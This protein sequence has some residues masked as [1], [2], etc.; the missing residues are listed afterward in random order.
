[1]VAKNDGLSNFLSNF[2][3]LS[4]FFKLA[5]QKVEQK[6]HSCHVVDVLAVLFYSH[7]VTENGVWLCNLVT[8]LMPKREIQAKVYSQNS[9][10]K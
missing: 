3:F 9:Q 6:I 1:M 2:T 10:R 5:Q 4:F 7:A 8:S